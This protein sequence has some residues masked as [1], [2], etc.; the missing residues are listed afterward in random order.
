MVS[1]CL[2]R[3]QGLSRT[4]F[5]GDAE[6]VYLREYMVTIEILVAAGALGVSFLGFVLVNL[7]RESW[8]A[9]RR[10]RGSFFG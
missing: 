2:C 1:A 6:C 4:L 5:A 7:V 10:S 8:K 9:K 3:V